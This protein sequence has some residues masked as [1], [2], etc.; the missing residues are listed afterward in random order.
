MTAPVE[1][2]HFPVSTSLPPSSRYA[3]IRIAP[4]IMA[5]SNVP[6]EA[7]E[8]KLTTPASFEAAAVFGASV[9]L[10]NFDK[11]EP[12]AWFMVADA[13]FAL[14]K[15]TDP[16]TKYYYFLSKLDATTLRKLSAFLKLPRGSD[17][18][19][20]IRDMLC[21]T[22]EPPLEQK[23]AALLTLSDIGDE[24]PREFGLEVRRLAS[25]TTLDDVL[26]RIFIRCLPHSIITAITGSLGGKLESVVAA[27]DKAWTAAASSTPT[28]LVSAVSG[29]PTRGSRRG[30]PQRET[31][32]PGNQTTTLTLCN[33]HRRFG[34]AAR[35]CAPACSCWAEDRPRDEQ[36][37][38]VFHVE[39]A[40]DGE[41]ANIGAALE[42]E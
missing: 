20:E 14:R 24:R 34:D 39:E 1:Q 16:M 38:Q 17:P 18:Y 33:F 42:N 30:E 32:R 26:K 2:P 19:Q 5:T 40:L 8:L 4:V 23:L 10:L 36:A 41:D 9:Q 28:A 22:Y 12:D 21:E 29:P 6:T 11:V 27:A 15:V 31:H 35:K 25:D 7:P 37:P 13:N 3:L